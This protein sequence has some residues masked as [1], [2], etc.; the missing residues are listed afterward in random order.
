MLGVAVNRYLSAIE[1]QR[2]LTGLAAELVVT[3]PGPFEA[4]TTSITLPHM[5][6][7]RAAENL[8][9]IAHIVLPSSPALISFSLT[10]QPR[11][12]WND[13]A[14]RPGDLV[15]HAPGECLHQ[16]TG[17]ASS[18]GLLSV[19]R[20]FLAR[21]GTAVLQR[22]VLTACE[23]AV[24]RVSPRES[25][26]FA[27]LHARAVEFVEKRPG[28]AAFPEVAQALEQDL[29]YALL[30]CFRNGQYEPPSPAR[31]FHT[32]VVNRLAA[33]LAAE[34]HRRLAVADLCAAIK[35]SDRMLGAC[36]RAVLGMGPVSY[37]RLYRLNRARAAI[38]DAGSGAARI[39]DLARKFGF[40]DA[41]RFAAAYRRAFGELPSA[42][43]SRP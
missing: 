5:V 29:L 23:G 41:G 26:E 9:R 8:P 40:G 10:A 31:S 33:M 2:G 20:A 39:A 24:L 1:F 12:L 7:L 4:R 6:L 13:S 42:T 3:S 36:C 34:P 37:M 32:A 43:M 28:R 38:I 35:I 22:P 27:R 30:C 19:D 18:W 25:A 17:G 11:M 14:M 16:R 15:L 21:H